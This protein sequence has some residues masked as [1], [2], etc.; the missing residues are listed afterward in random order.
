MRACRRTARARSANLDRV[1]ENQWIEFGAALVRNPE[2]RIDF[3][4]FDAARAAECE[5]RENHRRRTEEVVARM[6]AS[7]LAEAHP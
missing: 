1:I 3:K 5:E 7:Q 6:R 2:A 4:S